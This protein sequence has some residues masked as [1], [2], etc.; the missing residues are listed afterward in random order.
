M[1]WAKPRAR[2]HCSSPQFHIHTLTFLLH[3]APFHF[4][5]LPTF[6]PCH[7][8]THTTSPLHFHLTTEAWLHRCTRVAHAGGSRSLLPTYRLLDCC[9]H[10]AHLAYRRRLTF[11]TRHTCAFIVLRPRLSHGLHGLR[12]S[13]LPLVAA[14]TPLRRHVRWRL[15][16][17]RL[18]C[19]LTF[20]TP[21]LPA[22]IPPGPK[23]IPVTER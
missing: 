22:P 20:P 2:R 11:F 13:T 10:T 19:L 1:G 7:H 8:Y 15:R 23:H 5:C 21:P 3:A 14:Y 4:C 6:L 18:P 9:G 12:A 17:F 16:P